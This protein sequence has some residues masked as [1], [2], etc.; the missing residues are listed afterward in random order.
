[1]IQAFSHLNRLENVQLKRCALISDQSIKILLRNSISIEIL[2][3]SGCPNI[4]DKSLKAMAKYSAKL[5]ALTIQ[6]TNVREMNYEYFQSLFLSLI[7]R[8]LFSLLIAYWS[9]L[10][11]LSVISFAPDYE[12]RVDLIRFTLLFE[13]IGIPL[14]MRSKSCL[15]RLR[16]YDN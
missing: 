12:F 8:Y 6:K 5:R 9:T 10:I 13:I 15:T 16:V 3:L 7:I 14:K 2:N 11:L 1:M 4:K